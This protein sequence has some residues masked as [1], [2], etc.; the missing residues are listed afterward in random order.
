MSR[1]EHDPIN[2][3]RWH[4]VDDTLADGPSPA[5]VPEEARKWLRTLELARRFVVEA[6]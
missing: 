5:N 3:S 1:H 4:E 6:Y 2:D